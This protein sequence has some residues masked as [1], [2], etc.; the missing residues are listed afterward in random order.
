[1]LTIRNINKRTALGVIFILLGVL[2]LAVKIYNHDG[3]EEKLSWYISGSSESVKQIPTDREIV[4]YS[5]TIENPTNKSYVV[6]SVEPIISDAVKNLLLEQNVIIELTKNL[7]N[8]KN[9]QY[10]GQFE[11]NTSQLDEEGLKKLIPMIK[12][13]RVIYDNDQEIVLQAGSYGG[14]S[15]R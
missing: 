4:Y 3:E 7:P 2:I 14:M 6:K 1:M 9:V 15:G 12:S 5:M 13:Y 10:D 8:N 11:I